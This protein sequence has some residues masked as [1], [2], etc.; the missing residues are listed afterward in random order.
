MSAHTHTRTHMHSAAFVEMYMINYMIVHNVYPILSP[1]NPSC[2]FQ[3]GLRYFSTS[4]NDWIL[5]KVQKLVL[6]LI[7]SLNPEIMETRNI[8]KPFRLF[9]WDHWDCCLVSQNLCPLPPNLRLGDP[10]NFLKCQG[11]PPRTTTY[12]LCISSDRHTLRLGSIFGDLA[13]CV[14]MV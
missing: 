9:H 10:K 12:S 6:V 4:Q 11:N 14:W 5:A 13:C 2:T 1:T 7:E 3:F 8:T